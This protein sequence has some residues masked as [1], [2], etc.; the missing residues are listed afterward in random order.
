MLEVVSVRADT[1][2]R[3]K[4]AYSKILAQTWVQQS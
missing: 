1:P 2:M 3:C 4:E